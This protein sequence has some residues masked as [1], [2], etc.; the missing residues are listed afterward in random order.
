M[1]SS[2]HRLFDDDLAPA[3]NVDARPGEGAAC[4]ASAQVV[5]RIVLPGEG[6]GVAHACRKVGGR[7]VGCLQ[8]LLR[9]LELCRRIVAGTG[10]HLFSR[11]HRGE[12]GRQLWGV[13]LSRLDVEAAA[14]VV[15]GAQL[16][17]VGDG[18]AQ[19]RGVLHERCAAAHGSHRSLAVRPRVGRRPV[20]IAEDQGIACGVEV[21]PHRGGVLQNEL[22]EGGA[23]GRRH[24]LVEHEV[25][26]IGDEYCLEDALVAAGALVAQYVV[27]VGAAAAGEGIVEVCVGLCLVAVLDG[28]GL[29]GDVI[30][31]A[32]RLAEGAL[33]VGQGRLLYAAV[34]L[35][36]LLGGIGIELLGILQVLRVAVLLVELG[37]D[38]SG[39]GLRAGI[40]PAARV[41]VP[42]KPETARLLILVSPLDDEVV[43]DTLCRSRVHGR[44]RCLIDVQQRERNP[45]HVV[46]ERVLEHLVARALCCTGIVVGL[47]IVPGPDVAEVLA[48]KCAVDVLV[49]LVCVYDNVYGMRLRPVC[50]EGILVIAVVED[51]PAL[52]HERLDKGIGHR[53]GLG[54]VGV[55]D[56]TVDTL[57][58]CRLC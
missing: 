13:S 46:G 22:A 30:E 27:A 23:V 33:G 21:L 48:G 40:R 29:V 4:L 51:A 20:V 36:N 52:Y 3:R 38:E 26:G 14:L 43:K 42:G 17:A 53:V 39:R 16:A 28:Q 8:V 31:D 24:V 2:A 12:E 34:A 7:L 37:C 10:E 9:L 56:S 57:D 58:S 25:D 18:T 32:T 6:R 45:A 11:C 49:P 1:S 19:A 5:G 41:S 35:D 44:A 55:I 47:V 15:E 50:I 54:L